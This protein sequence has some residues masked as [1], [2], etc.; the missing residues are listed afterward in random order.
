MFFSFNFA[1]CIRS[2]RSNDLR[3]L[4]PTHRPRPQATLIFLLVTDNR[5]SLVGRATGSFQTNGRAISFSTNKATL[6]NG[7]CLPCSGTY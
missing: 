7:P 3:L 1:K 2:I 4:L 6:C 5:F